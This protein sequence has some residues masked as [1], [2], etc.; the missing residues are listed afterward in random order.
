VL[1][2]R[3]STMTELSTRSEVARDRALRAGKGLKT[4]NPV[5]HDLDHFRGV[6]RQSV[7][8]QGT[9]TGDLRKRLGIRKR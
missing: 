1:S 2:A 7:N 3:R 4:Y 8:S 5:F 6:L 9:G